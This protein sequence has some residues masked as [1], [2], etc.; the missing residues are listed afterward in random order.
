ML[1]IAK[2]LAGAALF[3]GCV[4]GSQ[5]VTTFN[6][7]DIDVDDGPQAFVLFG[8]DTDRDIDAKVTFTTSAPSF[9]FTTGLFGAA[10]SYNARVKV[11]NDPPTFFNQTFDNSTINEFV[12]DSSV[13][14]PETYALV[15]RI[16]ESGAVA[17]F[18]DVTA[19]PIPAAAWLFG[20]SLLAMVFVARRQN[21]ASSRA[22]AS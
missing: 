2:I 13:T 19:V 11:N 4:Q 7:G 6:L 12:A 15:F 10:D 17:L 16:P 3:L 18:G 21:A 14:G 9:R 1:P 8:V 20:S 5:A 22:L